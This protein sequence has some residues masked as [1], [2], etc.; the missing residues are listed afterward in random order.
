MDR[1]EKVENR[2]PSDASQHR[3]ECVGNDFEEGMASVGM[4][5]VM[6]ASHLTQGGFYRHFASNGELLAKAS[7][8]PQQ[9]T[10][11]VLNILHAE[12]SKNM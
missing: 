3:S 7:E 12:F 2:D 4:R 1:H 8:H 10:T 6:A 5:K 11:P 9:A